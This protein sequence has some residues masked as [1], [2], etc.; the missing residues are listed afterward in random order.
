MRGD[1]NS[2]SNEENEGQRIVVGIM[3]ETHQSQTRNQK[4]RWY[5]FQPSLPSRSRGRS[6]SIDG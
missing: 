6:S 1:F 5:L 4:A 3:N 2:S